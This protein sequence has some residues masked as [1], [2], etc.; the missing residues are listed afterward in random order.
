MRE[1]RGGSQPAAVDPNAPVITN[2]RASFGP[3]CTLQSTNLPGTVETLAFEY[4]DA[5]G[6][7]RGGTVENVVSAAVGGPR[8]LTETIMRF[9]HVDEGLEE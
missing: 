9:Q 3:R 8:P 1:Q 2:L 5:D 6:T 4:A 7:V